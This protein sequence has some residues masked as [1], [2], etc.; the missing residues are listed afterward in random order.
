[1]APHHIEV[2]ARHP[3]I[4]AVIGPEPG[5]VVDVLLLP[6]DHPDHGMGYRE[7]HRQNYMQ[8]S[9][10]LF[11]RERPGRGGVLIKHEKHVTIGYSITVCEGGIVLPGAP[12][13]RLTPEEQVVYPFAFLVGFTIACTS[14]PEWAEWARTEG[15][16]IPRYQ[17]HV[18]G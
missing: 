9:H 5:I 2:H 17:R 6:A 3:V 18:E 11:A 13:P 8:M 4:C 12:P 16:D 7:K 10:L 15:I 14:F 1:V